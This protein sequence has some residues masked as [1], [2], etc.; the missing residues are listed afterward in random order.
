MSLS[1]ISK[2]QEGLENVKNKSRENSVDD[3]K[4]EVSDESGKLNYPLPT[5]DRPQTRGVLKN[6][7]PMDSIVEENR[8]A[9]K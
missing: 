9:E 8:T 6:C 4:I 5:R 2:E 1:S 3:R 7:K